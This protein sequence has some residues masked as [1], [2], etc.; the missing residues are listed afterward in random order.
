MVGSGPQGG[1]PLPH[2]SAE[3]AV[4][5]VIMH[6]GKFSSADRAAYRKYKSE[7]HIVVQSVFVFY[8][9]CKNIVRTV[10]NKTIKINS[11]RGHCS[12]VYG[13]QYQ[14]GLVQY[15]FAVLNQLLDVTV[16]HDN[17]LRYSKGIPFVVLWPVSGFLKLFVESEG[18][19]LRCPV[20]VGSLG[21]L[22]MHH[23]QSENT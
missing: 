17:G 16:S 7:E 15:F 5:L 23:E 8:S 19:T 18:N 10:K 22:A 2:G 12:V 21:S 20:M 3:E 13:Y 14:I 4:H 6:H 9:L 11:P 1:I